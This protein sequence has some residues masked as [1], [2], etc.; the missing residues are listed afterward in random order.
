MPGVEWS[1]DWI[2][3][4]REKIEA[5]WDRPSKFTR[6]LYNINTGHRDFNKY[7]FDPDLKTVTPPYE[8]CVSKEKCNHMFRS[9]LS[10]VF[11]A[12][13]FLQQDN[14]V[15]YNTFLLKVLVAYENIN[16]YSGIWTQDWSFLQSWYYSFLMQSI[17]L[18]LAVLG[19]EACVP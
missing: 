14:T 2:K 13:H 4:I 9:D 1:P 10:F 5:L 17:H 8:R 12:F 11:L 6:G 16:D 15:T 19:P 3:I 7:V 18:M